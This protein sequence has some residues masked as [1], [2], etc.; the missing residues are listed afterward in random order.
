MEYEMAFSP[1]LVDQLVLEEWVVLD[2]SSYSLN[3]DGLGAFPQ[4]VSSRAASQKIIVQM[5]ARGYGR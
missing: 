1:D 3:L 4:T 5:A 2:A